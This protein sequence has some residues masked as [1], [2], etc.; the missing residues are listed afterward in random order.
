MGNASP[1]RCRGSWENC[2]APSKSEASSPAPSDSKAPP[3]SGGA[4]ILVLVRFTSPFYR[5][6]CGL[7]DASLQAMRIC[8]MIS[9]GRLTLC[10]VLSQCR[11]DHRTIC[12]LPDA[13]HILSAFVRRC[14][15]S[16]LMGHVDEGSAS[17]SGFGSGQCWQVGRSKQGNSKLGKETHACS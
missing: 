15:W 14:F 7:G 8:F 4:L 12:H 1:Q 2:L 9:L 11:I 10:S 13:H 16:S 6:L 3:N 17:I 5:L